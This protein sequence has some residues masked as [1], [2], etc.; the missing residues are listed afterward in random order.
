[1]DCRAFD[2]G[3]FLDDGVV[4]LEPGKYCGRAA[5]RSP[6]APSGD[7]TMQTARPVAPAGATW[8]SAKAARRF[9]SRHSSA[10]EL[11]ALMRP[12]ATNPWRAVLMSLDKRKSTT[13]QDWRKQQEIPIR[14]K[15][16]RFMQNPLTFNSNSHKL[17]G[18][19]F[20]M[21]CVGHWS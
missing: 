3:D 2:R 6:P 14:S 15:Y 10:V 1:M 9:P 19:S 20:A 5:A 4:F 18:R 8:R 7:F 17:S 16:R 11:R 21:L 13:A 12:M